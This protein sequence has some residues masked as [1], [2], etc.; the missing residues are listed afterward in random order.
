MRYIKMFEDY[1]Y[2]VE[3]Y[4]FN[5]TD[6]LNGES[7]KE[8]QPGNRN[9]IGADTFNTALVESGFPDKKKCV[10]FMDK[11][12]FDPSFRSIYGKYTYTINIDNQS[13]LG[14]SF[15]TPIND[16]YYL[17][18]QKYR[19]LDPNILK[20]IKENTPIEL[21]NFNESDPQQSINR[22]KKI[23]DYG[24]IGFGTIDDLRSNPLFG[25]VPLFVWTEDK[26]MVHK[27]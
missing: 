7:E 26:V 17:M 12:A 18:Q 16:W 3:F 11:L 4:R 19:A 22:I 14:W 5:H 10:H 6:L 9:I 23:M 15:Y 13:Y 24:F 1:I 2:D 27:L 8:I 21:D 25:K 20:D